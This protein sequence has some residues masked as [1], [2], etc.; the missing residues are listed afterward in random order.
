LIVAPGPAV[1]TEAP[2]ARNRPVPMD[3]PMAIMVRW[4]GFKTRWRPLS[5]PPP[6]TS[7]TG[8]ASTCDACA[9]FL[10]V[11]NVGSRT[12]FHLLRREAFLKHWT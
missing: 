6:L 8:A 10:S 1:A 4:R 11:G 3:P 9:E 7:A 5:A 12:E 2:D